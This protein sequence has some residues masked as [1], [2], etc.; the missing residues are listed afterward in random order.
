[1]GAR[2][3]VS[4]RPRR[5]LIASPGAAAVGALLLAGVGVR[6]YAI[7]SYPPAVL[8]AHAHDAAN[9]VEAARLGLGRG[10]QEPSGYP[11]FLR[12]A[13]FISHQLV[14]TIAGQHAFGIAAGALLFLAVR[15]LGAP[16]WAACVPAAI[17]WLNGDELFLEHALLSEPLSAAALAATL[18]AAV[19]ALHG[20]VGWPLAVGV[21][22]ASFADDPHRERAAPPA[23]RDL[24][25]RRVAPD[26]PAVDASCRARPPGRDRR[27]WQAYARGSVRGG[28]TSDLLPLAELARTPLLAGGRI[29]PTAGTSRHRGAPGCCAI[30]RRPASV[31]ARSITCGWA[32]PDAQPSERRPCTTICWRS[33]HWPRSSTSRWTTSGWWGL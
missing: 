19:R 2:V 3:A 8:T 6:I 32:A 5:Q 12:A 14:I 30:E 20:G 22:V 16:L 9:Y 25:G 28:G 26:G 29:S 17:L 33:S 1:M 13:H 23:G 4:I 21:L 15:R 10:A 7:L 27:F 18:Y 24:A 31:L 11:L